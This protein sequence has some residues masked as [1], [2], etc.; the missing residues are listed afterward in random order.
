MKRII[1]LGMSGAGKTTL[2]KAIAAKCD[3]KHIEM[4]AIRHHAN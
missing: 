3:I 1:I 2:A 4:D